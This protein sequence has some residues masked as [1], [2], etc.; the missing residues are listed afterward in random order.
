MEDLGFKKLEQAAKQVGFD[1]ARKQEMRNTVMRF[2][3]TNPLPTAVVAKKVQ[4]WSFHVRR[5]FVYASAFVIILIIGT[6]TTYAANNALPGQPLYGFKVKVLEEVKSAIVFSSEAKT[7][8]EIDR[9]TLRL[10][11]VDKLALSN[12][13]TTKAKTEA[14]INFKKSVDSVQKQIETQEQNGKS[15][16][17]QR[18]ALRLEAALSAHD[19]I[20]EQVAEDRKDDGQELQPLQAAVKNSLQSTNTVRRKLDERRTEK[21]KA[22]KTNQ[23]GMKAE[24]TAKITSAEQAIARA[25][26]VI[27]NIRGNKEVVARATLQLEQ[28][29]DRVQKAQVS[30]KAEQYSEAVV[31]ADEA[32]SIAQEVKIIAK[33]QSNLKVDLKVNLPSPGNGTDQDSGDRQHNVDPT[34]PT[35]SGDDNWFRLRGRF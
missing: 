3:N 5:S 4:R 7:E 32:S 25:A 23:V 35:E 31:L 27:K 33:T 21:H 18:L 15:E 6:G 2:M 10:E 13:L 14:E 26:G 34:D 22:E 1:P 17:A 12:N 16:I 24:A 11:E 19:R 29:S 9:A 28:A 30:F 20:L 8:A